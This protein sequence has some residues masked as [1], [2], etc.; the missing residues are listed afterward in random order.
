MPDILLCC[1]YNIS[2]DPRVSLYD[3]ADLWVQELNG[4]D[5]VGGENPNLA[6]LGM[7]GALSSMEGCKAFGEMLE[8]TKIGSWYDRMKG[9]IQE[10]RGEYK[11]MQRSIIT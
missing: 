3:Q 5:F 11:L 6:D 10:R 1:R 7:Y 8:N 9:K 4:E 2:P